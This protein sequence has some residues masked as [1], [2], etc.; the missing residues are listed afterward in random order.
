MIKCKLRLSS[1]SN[2]LMGESHLFQ[3]RNCLWREFWK[4]PSRLGEK[5]V[6]GVR[7]ERKI[8]QT[9]VHQTTKANYFRGL[10][11]LRVSRIDFGDD[12]WGFFFL[13]QVVT[14]F[15]NDSNVQ[16]EAPFW[17]LFG[18]RLPFKVIDKSN[19]IDVVSHL[20]DQTFEEC[21]T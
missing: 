8:F 16:R 15:R 10:D 17:S 13:P 7:R 2:P 5:L 9:G 20:T 1:A 4:T 11:G 19:L 3:T 21:V 18:L 12:L 14:T 6:E